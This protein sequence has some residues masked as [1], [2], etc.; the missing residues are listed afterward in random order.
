MAADE[1][2]KY[3]ADKIK[4]EGKWSG[5]RT[6]QGMPI[7]AGYESQYDS[8]GIY[9][10]PASTAVSAAKA[11][12]NLAV[13]NAGG[14][15][16]I[17]AQGMNAI[18]QVNLNPERSGR[19]PYGLLFYTGNSGQRLPDGR[20]I[21]QTVPIAYVKGNFSTTTTTGAECR[22]FQIGYVQNLKNGLSPDNAASAA[23]QGLSRVQAN[24]AAV[25][26]IN[27]A[28]NQ[29]QAA[30]NVKP[31]TAKVT[32][33]APN[34]PAAKPSSKAPVRAPR[35]SSASSGPEPED[36]GIAIANAVAARNAAAAAVQRPIAPVKVQ[37][38]APKP[39]TR[40]VYCGY[41]CIIRS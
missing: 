40:Q 5:N 24:F 26:A 15:S 3:D 10:G 4:Y 38:A 32:P 28:A 8:R 18:N 39:V 2:A 1:K 14:G 30:A 9:I 22:E 19:N 34:K 31:V 17:S 35:V 13:N 16:G 37:P 20:I 25:A 41:G 36:A 27:A 7:A 33:T 12:A 11:G 29:T 21:C 23:I 6:A